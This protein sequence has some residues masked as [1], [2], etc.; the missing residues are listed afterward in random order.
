MRVLL[1]CR[2]IGYKR[3]DRGERREGS[4]NRVREGVEGP[5]TVVMLSMTVLCWAQKAE[6][7]GDVVHLQQQF[8][9]VQ[10]RK[11]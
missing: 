11:L 4:T 5:A 8:A 10:V 9:S 2:R 7:A 1:Y 3:R 6:G